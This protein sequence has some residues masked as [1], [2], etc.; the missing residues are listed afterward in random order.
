MDGAGK[1]TVMLTTR[2]TKHTRRHRGGTHKRVQGTREEGARASTARARRHTVSVNK[3]AGKRKNEG[4]IRAG[5]C[6]VA[7]RVHVSSRAGQAR[8]Y[9]FFK[10]VYYGLTSAKGVR[11]IKIE[12]HLLRSC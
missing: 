3:Q 5:R 10:S 4:K 7:R 9:F 6:R 1:L 12:R 2:K 8:S 11:N